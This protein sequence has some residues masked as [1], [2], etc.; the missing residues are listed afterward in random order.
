VW[1]SD[2]TLWAV[3][4]AKDPAIAK[5]R[6]AP[7]LS[8]SLRRALSLRLLERTIQV[9]DAT[10]EVSRWVVI[11]NALEPLALARRLGGLA[12]H[13]LRSD[14]E[15]GDPDTTQQ[16]AVE[17]MEATARRAER[18]L[19][20]ALQQAAAVAERNGATALLVLH[21]DLL[22]LNSQALSGF[23]SAG[24]LSSGEASGGVTGASDTGQHST[25]DVA[26][27][28]Q[29]AQLASV[30]IAPDR[31]GQGTNALLLRP[32]GAIQFA[33]G[34]QSY[35]RHLALAS[36]IGAATTV[37]NDTRFAIDLDTP[38]D[39][40]L[41]YTLTPDLDPLPGSAR[42]VIDGRQQPGEIAADRTFLA[43]SGRRAWGSEE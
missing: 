17:E 32:P 15:E 34:P 36:E 20:A 24:A 26:S 14:T 4:P 16:G 19:N 38:E 2:Q 43:M 22:L 29:V 25:A 1:R 10:P 28:V 13:E 3:I 18:R 23:I 9:V 30:T 27:L 33:F 31:H 40:D 21:A 11:S 42:Q 35:T 6:L 41:L 5:S 8:P 12:I 39:L 7:R 37:H